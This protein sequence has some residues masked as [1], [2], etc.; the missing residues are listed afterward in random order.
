MTSGFA[1][2]ALIENHTA[3]GLGIERK[4][5]DQSEV[6]L[7]E[8]WLHTPGGPAIGCQKKK[9]VLRN[10]VKRLSTYPASERVQKLHM[11]EPRAPVRS[12]ALGPG[13]S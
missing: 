13:M 6:A 1:A 3:G 9:R 10:R 12:H 2:W 4:L 11:V 8:Y 5:L 7:V